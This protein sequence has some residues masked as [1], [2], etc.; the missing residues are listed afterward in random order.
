MERYHFCLFTSI[1]GYSIIFVR[2]KVF[3][4]F[5]AKSS[6]VFGH[7]SVPLIAP[8]YTYLLLYARTENRM[9][10]PTEYLFIYLFIHTTTAHTKGWLSVA[11]K[12]KNSDWITP[13]YLDLPTQNDE[14]NFKWK[15]KTY[16]VLTYYKGCR[17]WLYWLQVPN[18]YQEIYYIRTI[19]FNQTSYCEDLSAKLIIHPPWLARASRL[20]WV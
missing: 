19:A 2:K 10:S 14:I 8:L 20:Q 12:G 7:S 6:N 15:K 5:A 13:Q 9:T 4:I 11:I 3:L 1:L 17:D 18:T 16:F